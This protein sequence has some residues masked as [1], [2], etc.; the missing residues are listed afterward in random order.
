M[1][2]RT[3]WLLAA[4][5]LA[6]VLCCWTLLASEPS[7][8]VATG[9]AHGSPAE[10]APAR[11]DLRPVAV[12]AQPETARDLPAP[13]A[14]AA[15]SAR[16]AVERPAVPSSYF[17]GRLVDRRTGEGLENV[18]VRMRCSDG[19]VDSSDTTDAK[20]RFASTYAYAPT[21]L[22][23]NARC[24]LSGKVLDK[25]TAN[26]NPGAD[27]AATGELLWPVEV[28]PTLY[29]ELDG[30]PAPTSWKARI[31]ERDDAGERRE[32]P[33]IEIHRHAD[34]LMARY[35]ASCAGPTPPGH[36]RS[37]S[38]TTKGSGRAAPGSRA[39]SAC[40]TCASACGRRSPRSSVA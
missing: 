31:V 34:G 1:G 6:L 29:L 12:E 11:V 38:A 14:A 23:L 15:Q 35:P 39:R 27:G 32:W 21:T 18:F 28:G 22:L 7:G 17:R 4:G 9:E 40:R 26:H 16:E 2:A 37:R 33:W 8:E 19:Q 3:S 24:K 10:A 5:A 13:A 25:F 20:G 36:P 30:G